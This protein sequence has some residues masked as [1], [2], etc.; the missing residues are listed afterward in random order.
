MVPELRPRGIGEM[1]DTAVRLYRS[2]ARHLILI[3][4]LV[5]VPVQVLNTIVLLSAQPSG[6]KIGPTGGVSP[7]Y[8]S[9]A[10]SAQLAAQFIVTILPL[11]ATAFVVAICARIVADAYSDRGDPG[12]VA[13]REAGRRALSVIG[14]E[15]LVLLCFGLGA[16]ACLIGVVVPMTWFAV[17]MPALILERATVGGAMSRSFNLTKSHFFRVLGLVLSVQLLTIVIS[18]GLAVGVNL[19]LHVG[20]NASSAVIAQGLA[21][22]IATSLTTPFAAT[23]IVVCYFDLRIRDEGFD[24]QLMMQAVDDRHA[25]A[26]AALVPPAAG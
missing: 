7:T 13:A 15:I 12:K 6:F 21:N 20:G 1:L 25:T 16:I 23:A 14:L 19:F 8:D 10:A 22:I 18:A 24:I 9:G 17:A 4:A 3:A 11:L 2:R 5:I 26:R